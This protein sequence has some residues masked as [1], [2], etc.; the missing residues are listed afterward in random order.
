MSTP[1]IC[2][3]IFLF[4]HAYLLDTQRAYL[5]SQQIY[6]KEMSFHRNLQLTKQK[7]TQKIF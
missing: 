6:K 2:Y 1:D 7:P 3:T 4:L 5:K